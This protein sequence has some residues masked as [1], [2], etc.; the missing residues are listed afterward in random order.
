VSAHSDSASRCPPFTPFCFRYKIPPPSSIQFFSISCFSVPVNVDTSFSTSLLFFFFLPRH[1]TIHVPYDASMFA[2]QLVS[3][4]LSALAASLPA[5]PPTL[6]APSLTTAFSLS[7][8]LLLAA[9]PSLTEPR[10]PRLSLMSRQ[11]LHLHTPWTRAPPIPT[12]RSTSRS[13]PAT[14]PPPRGGLL[15]SNGSP[16][17]MICKFTSRA[18]R[19]TLC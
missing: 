7:S 9:S 12:P 19:R 10:S 16:V 3:S 11:E 1:G 2:L 18:I 6:I 14:V 17:S 4:P 5:R 15:L 8:S 13:S